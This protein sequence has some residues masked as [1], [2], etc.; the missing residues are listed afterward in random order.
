MSD[1]S[2][3]NRLSE[4]Y[5]SLYKR[6]ETDFRNH[7]LRKFVLKAAS[8]SNAL[9]VGCGTGHLAL[10][11]LKHG[12]SVVAVDISPQMVAFTKQTTQPYAH[13]VQILKLRA[14]ELHKLGPQTFDL[15]TCVDVLEHIEF[16]TQ[17]L[18]GIRERLNKHGQFLLVVPAHK[19]LYGV[20]DREMGHFRR[21]SRAEI[22]QK[23][24]QCGFTIRKLCFWNATG[25]LPYF[26]S[27]KVFRRPVNE[28]LRHS[29]QSQFASVLN[30]LFR[31]W[32]ALFENHVHLGFGLSLFIVAEKSNPSTA[33]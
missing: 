9:E 11:L 5:T 6:Q 32:F 21:Y 30:F 2:K 8:G 15:I 16:D 20:R 24:T 23:M 17:V 14:E 19:C 26:I 18:I 3:R 33:I 4:H 22:Q 25:V 7:N 28:S 29:P 31:Q 1:T 10:D 12:F 13:Q 27:E